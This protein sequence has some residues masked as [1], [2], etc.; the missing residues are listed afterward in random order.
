[1]AEPTI[2]KD[3]IL[4]ATEG[5]LQ[6]QFYVV[7]TSP[8]DGMGPVMAALEEH[9]AFLVKLGQDGIL[10]GAGP[11]WADDEHSWNGEGMVIL[12]ADSL[13]HAN[14]IAGEDPMHSTGARK[15]T[16]RP[17]LLNEGGMSVQIDFST[18][19]YTVT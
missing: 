19:S 18:G 16:V 15:F 12:R 9:L 3:D 11:H 7:S 5:M 1:M 8:I 14:K 13:A 17:W 2:T 6:K 4:K 10:F